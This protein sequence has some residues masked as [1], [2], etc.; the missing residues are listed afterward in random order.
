MDPQGFSQ[1]RHP[2]FSARL[3]TPAP[4]SSALHK[5]VGVN[6]LRHKSTWDTP[7]ASGLVFVHYPGIIA[8]AEIKI[9]TIVRRKSQVTWSERSPRGQHAASGS[10]AGSHSVLTTTGKGDVTAGAGQAERLRDV[11]TVPRSASHVTRHQ[12]QVC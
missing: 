9:V 6:F 3:A 4:L 11:L 5:A 7:T 12:I 8:V 10:N 1:R 2:V